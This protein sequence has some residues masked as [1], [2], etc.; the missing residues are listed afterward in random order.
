M[1]K[2]LLIMSLILFIS[3][4]GVSAEDLNQDIS[5]IQSPDGGTFAELQDKI[6]NADEGSTIKLENNYTYEDS[7][8]D[9]YITISKNITLDGDGHT[10]DANSASGIFDITASRVVLN[11]I[12]F[13][14]AVVDDDIGS[15]ILSNGDLSINNCRFAN[16]FAP[17]YSKGNLTV[18]NST[19]NGNINDYTGGGADAAVLRHLFRAAAS[20]PD[21]AAL[22]EASAADHPLRNGQRF[23]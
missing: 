22:A 4:A 6:N 13:I 1:R 23:R 7:F 16:S 21:H 20:E 2:I 10:I 5:L 8:K 17:I 11:N 9:G 12:A 19:F 3:I 14:N 18:I 15:A